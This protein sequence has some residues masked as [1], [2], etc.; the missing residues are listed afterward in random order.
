MVEEIPLF[1][2]KSSLLPTLNI[3]SSLLGKS[4]TKKDLF[5]Y[6]LDLSYR[7]QERV[8][9][10]ENLKEIQQCKYKEK[11]LVKRRS[12][13]EEFT[14]TIQENH[15]KIEERSL[16]VQNSGEKDSKIVELI[17]LCPGIKDPN[18]A[19]FYLEAQGYNVENA[20]KFYT[21]CTGRSN[22]A[23]RKFININFVL[24]EKVEFSQTY[25]ETSLM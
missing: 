3:D 2:V 6:E 4:I 8:N 15:K 12:V 17:S 10:I 22:V 9:E 18:E 23:R 14:K 20:K 1:K 16:K 13:G 5:S 25:D 24:P 21:S 19:K 7:Y 11:D